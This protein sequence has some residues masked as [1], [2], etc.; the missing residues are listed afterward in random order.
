MAVGPTASWRGSAG[1]LTAAIDPLDP[2]LRSSTR[3]G[4]VRTGV[5]QRGA[6]GAIPRES[7]AGCVG[8]D[9]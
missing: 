5:V 8:A 4:V 6:G 7:Y 2:A 1:T 9:R 3:G